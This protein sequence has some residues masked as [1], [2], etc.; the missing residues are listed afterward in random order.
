MNTGKAEMFSGN[1]LTSQA[2]MASACLPTLFPRGRDRRRTLLGWWLFG[3]P[4]LTPLIE[5]CNSAD[6]VLVQLNPLKRDSV[7]QT[8][9]EI[10]DRMNE[11]TFNASLLTQM[12]AIEFINR[13]LDDG[14]LQGSRSASACCCIASTWAAPW[15]TAGRRLQALDR[16]P[17][18]IQQ[19]FELGRAAGAQWLVAHFDALG[20]R[21]TVNIS[22][23][24][25]ASEIVKPAAPQ[26]GASRPW[27]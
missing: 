6:M 16:R 23:D 18:M 9:H 12:R 2:V 11:L 7:P 8:P 10:M 20:R 22:R 19:L 13:L 4:G 3:E 27:P 14:W 1:A 26:R 17:A 21:S 5:H 15:T 24:Y 25:M